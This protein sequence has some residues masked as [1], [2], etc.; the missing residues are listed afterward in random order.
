MPLATI[1][2]TQARV[3]LIGRSDRFVTKTFAYD[4]KEYFVHLPSEVEFKE[5]A[6]ISTGRPIIEY[7]NFKEG[8]K[9]VSEKDM[10]IDWFKRNGI[11]A[12]NIVTEDPPESRLRSLPIP[13]QIRDYLGKNVKLVQTGNDKRVAWRTKEE[14]WINIS[15]RS[16]HALYMSLRSG[17]LNDQDR[18]LVSVLA[19]VLSLKLDDAVNQLASAIVT[20]Q[21]R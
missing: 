5:Q 20:G 15:N 10:I 12:I 6:L 4:E 9:P 7:I 19:D 16:M 1:Q 18:F 11:Q 8:W 13:S 14:L 2:D 17:T 21:R 3:F